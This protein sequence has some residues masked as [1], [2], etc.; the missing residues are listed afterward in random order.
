MNT[1][2]I[3]ADSEKDANMFYATGILVPDD[4]V[5][6]EK[7]GKKIIYVSD[8]EF[9]RA[10]KEAKVDEVINYSKYD[11]KANRSSLGQVVIE[12]LKENKIKK[13]LVPENFKMKYAQFLQKNKISIQVKPEPFF[14]KR[15]VKDNSEIAKIKESQRINEKAIAEAIRIIKRS[16]IRRDKKLSYKNKVLTSEFVKF[17]IDVELLKGGCQSEFNIVSCGKDSADPHQEG[18]GPLFAHQPIVIDIFPRS[19]SGGACYFADTTRTVVRGKAS[20]EIKKIYQAV[21][22]AQK[23]GISKVKPEIEASVVHRSVQDYFNDHNFITE[24]KNGKMQGFIHSTGHGV[25]MEIHELPGITAKSKDV[26]KA[27]NI[28]TVEPGLYYPDI[29]GVRIEDLILVTKNGHEN[30]TKL[31]KILEI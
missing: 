18:R 8:L 26:L 6:L 22:Q 16:K 11:K 31:P 2:L 9:N 20:P 14:E 12:A 27:G 19:K 24:E 5:Y 21:L 29:G 23:L 17:A 3:I 1:K 28:I 30:L 7:N 13:V 4:F 25:G 15:A 10:Q